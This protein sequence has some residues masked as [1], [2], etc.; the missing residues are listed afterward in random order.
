MPL[1]ERRDLTQYTESLARYLPHGKLFAVKSA[2]NSNFRKLLRGLAHELFEA[3]GL[4]RQY[5]QEIIPDQTERFI[6]EWESALGLPDECVDI[7]GSLEDRRNNILAKLAS[8]GVQTIADFENMAAVF[9]FDVTVVAGADSGLS[10]GSDQEMRHTIVV[11]ASP[12]ET[13]TYT[14]PIPFGDARLVFLECMFNRLKPAN[15][16]VLFELI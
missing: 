16:Q 10:F 8:L 4:L 15:A 6:E 11:N 5:N 2:Q 12:A 1:F 14:F 13:F 9:G 7:S 3:N